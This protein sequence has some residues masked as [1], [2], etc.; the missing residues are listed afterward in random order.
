M[1]S[2]HPEISDRLLSY[3]DRRLDEQD[4]RQVQEHLA[5]CGACSEE[6]AAIRAVTVALRQAGRDS[7]AADV[8]ADRYGCPG[9][10]E[11]F[12][13]ER[14]GANLPAVESDWVSQHLEACQR[15]QHE[16]DLVHLMGRE[17]QEAAMPVTPRDLSA[18][19][20]GRLMARVRQGKGADHGTS[21]LDR[22][23]SFGT[24]FVARAALGIGLVAVIA[25][26]GLRYL[27]RGPT[28]VAQRS[29]EQEVRPVTPS[30]SSPGASRQEPQISPGTKRGSTP[31][32]SEPAP[33]RTSSPTPT[34]V[35]KVEPPALP[36]S[37]SP[38]VVARV[39]PRPLPRPQPAV[40]LIAVA[41]PITEQAKEVPGRPSAGPSLP[42][43]VPAKQGE[44]LK[45]LILPNRSRP[46]LR[47]AVAAGLQE[48]I[49][50]LQ[51][52]ER[53]F[54]PE[55]SIDDLTANRRLGRLFGVRYVLEIGVR[56]E[57][58]GYRVVLRA[59]DTDTGGIVGTRE[60]SVTQ[61]RELTA[62]ARQLASELRQQLK[63]MP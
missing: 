8:A 56:Q 7:R 6:L 39:E 57:A 16:V 48:D 62:V 29:S 45:V 59:A 25:I 11:L 63:A 17:L 32:V 61:E 9:P 49:G 55:P 10:E 31:P 51:P 24:Y 23:P 54:P 34:V 46:D 43:L 38:S 19:V 15:C 52:P 21:L 4:S 50:T 5:S 1:P 42:P 27:Q 18:K 53:E 20:E 30:V 58:S 12:S 37:P 41:P 40:P 13:Y 36:S 60:G 47:L 26:V 3:L 22:L 28:L 44:P 33:P 35:A 14:R 2:I